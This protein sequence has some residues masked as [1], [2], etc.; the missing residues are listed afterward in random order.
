MDLLHRITW[1]LSYQETLFHQS[2]LCQDILL[3]DPY[4]TIHTLSFHVSTRQLA[5]RGMRTLLVAKL[6][7]LGSLWH[8]LFHL[9]I[10]WWHVQVK[11]QSPQGV[12]NHQYLPFSVTATTL[13][14][15]NGR[16]QILCL[17]SQIAMPH[18]MTII[19]ATVEESILTTR[20]HQL[21]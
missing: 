15:I 6:Q 14:T 10:L 18:A 16:Q 1:Y 13:Q 4:Q 2:C 8:A 21:W 9:S 5:Q 17:I 11:S 19:Q 20:C 3:L 7:V 12:V